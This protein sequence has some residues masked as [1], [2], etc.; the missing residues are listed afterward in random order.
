MSISSGVRVMHKETGLTAYS[1][2]ERSMTANKRRCMEILKFKLAF[3]KSVD[4][5]IPTS[6]EVGLIDDWSEDYEA[7]EKTQWGRGTLGEPWIPVSML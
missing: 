5:G 1:A 7:M 4:L 6:R 3:Q 2:S